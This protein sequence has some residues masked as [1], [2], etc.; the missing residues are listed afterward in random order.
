MS[1]IIDRLNPAKQ[2]KEVML[3]NPDDNRFTSLKVERE[4]ESLVYCKKHD[5]I[6]YRFFK[7][8]PGWTGNIIRFLAVEGT[9]VISYIQ[10]EKTKT[11]EKLIDFLKLALGEDNFNKLEPA[12]KLRLE[13]RCIGGTVTVKPFIPDSGMQEVFDEVKAESILYDADLQNTAN[14]G[15]SIEIKPW[16]DKIFD[17]VPWILT[18]VALNYIAEAVGLLN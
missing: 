7:L 6:L 11:T 16:T 8:G 2:K 12:L 13:E 18:G 15:E 4:T 10:E 1:N 14:L 3:L 9:P 5:G 17:K